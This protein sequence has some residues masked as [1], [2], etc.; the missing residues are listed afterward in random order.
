MPKTAYHTA[1]IAAERR[2][3]ILQRR[4]AALEERGEATAARF[5]AIAAEKVPR[6]SNDEDHD[7]GDQ[8]CLNLSTLLSGGGA[9]P[10]LEMMAAAQEGERLSQSL[11]QDIKNDSCDLV[12]NEADTTISNSYLYADA[13]EGDT[14]SEETNS[15][16]ASSDSSSNSYESNPSVSTNTSN[17][18]QT[19]CP[20]ENFSQSSRSLPCGAKAITETPPSYRDIMPK[21]V[22]PALFSAHSLPTVL[23]SHDASEGS[24][25]SPFAYGSAGMNCL[26][27]FMDENDDDWNVAKI[28]A[29]S[30][31]LAGVK[32]GKYFL[33]PA[34]KSTTPLSPSDTLPSTNPTVSPIMSTTARS[35][36]ASLSPN[37]EDLD[38][39]VPEDT[40]S[41]LDVSDLTNPT[42][43][44]DSGCGDLPRSHDLSGLE[45]GQTTLHTMEEPSEAKSAQS[46]QKARLFRCLVVTLL[47]GAFLCFLSAALVLCNHLFGPFRLNTAN[48]IAAESDYQDDFTGPAVTD[49]IFAGGSGE[50]VGASIAQTSSPPGAPVLQLV[51][52]AIEHEPF[53]F[54]LID[55]IPQD[56]QEIPTSATADDAIFLLHIGRSG[57]ALACSTFDAMQSTLNDLSLPALF[58]PGASDWSNCPGAR[59]D[60]FA[61]FER[62]WPN[63]SLSPSSIDIKGGQEE[64]FKFTYSD[65]LFIGLNMVVED[66]EAAESRQRLWNNYD[67]VQETLTAI[68]KVRAI[69]IFGYKYYDEFFNA[70]KPVIEVLGLPVIYMCVGE[71]DGLKVTKRFGGDTRDSA[72]FW[73]VELGESSRDLP[74]LKVIVS[75]G[76]KQ[77]VPD[78][79]VAGFIDLDRP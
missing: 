60:T 49:N 63:A 29:G 54:F 16:L 33:S 39:R 20:S 42:T 73:S 53:S 66:A 34:T 12:P 3:Q 45:E 37:R 21:S 25:D 5:L 24:D 59:T 48:S 56:P 79:R 38:G 19:T 64:N 26:G 7:Q 40:G 28:V 32:K 50:S 23:V 9:C 68:D 75:T 46:E 35:N 74:P 44:G 78:D 11:L 8:A 15:I 77:D 41:L 51:Q 67:W 58:L 65:V 2:R 1:S 62:N 4:Q 36:D 30:G 55:N 43:F 47:V 61:S 76:D 72:M 14:S 10:V 52:D 70:L 57:E 13:D 27:L 69:I 71:D 22:L 31:P 6:Q 17:R 18:S